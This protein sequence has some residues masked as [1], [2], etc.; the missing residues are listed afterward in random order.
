M[1][2]IKRERFPKCVVCKDRGYCTVC[3]MSNANEN[4]DGDAF[5]VND[6]HCKVASLIH[7]KIDSYINLK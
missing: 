4:S 5:R 1:R 2:Q 3:M 7:D 6:F